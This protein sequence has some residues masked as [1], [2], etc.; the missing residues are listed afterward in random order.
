[1]VSSSLGIS[2]EEFLETLRRIAGENA[3]DEE[4]L[5]LRASF[6]PEFPF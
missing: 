6:P 3:T 2:L 1:M 5:R 4:Y